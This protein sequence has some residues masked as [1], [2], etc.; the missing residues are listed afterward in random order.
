M[1]GAQATI[2]TAAKRARLP[3]RKNPYWHGVSGGRGGVSL[4]YRKSAKGRPGGWIG[5]I[6]VEG[7]RIEERVGV[8]D[9]PGAGPGALPYPKAVTAALDWAHQR[10]AAIEARRAGGAEDARPTVHTAVTAYIAERRGRSLHGR[11]AHSRLTKHVLADDAFAATPLGKLTADLIGAWRD[12]L[13]QELSASTVN[14]LLNDLRAALNAAAVK[15]RRQLPAH[16]AAE[17]RAGTKAAPEAGEARRQILSDGDV[18]RIVDEAFAIEPEGDFGRLVLLA[19]ATGARFS[20]LAA[21]AVADVQAE[22]LRIMVPAS[23]KGRSAKAPGRIAVPIG[24]DVLE[25]LQPALV[26]RGGHEP[27]LMHWIKRQTGPWVWE[28]SGRSAWKS[29]SEADRLWSRTVAAAR[30]PPETVMYALRHSS[31][32]RGLRAGLPVRLVAALHDTSTAMVEKHYAA[33]I[34][35]A[36]EELARRAVMLLASLAPGTHGPEANEL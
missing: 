20:Q 22:R 9:D 36:T 30:L 32:V 2:D 33:F 25:R 10:Y 12:R 35:D 3:A 24:P 34:V 11:D 29:A 16:L 6:V 17:I 5:K 14:R 1:A 13:S 15:H 18:R 23:K 4:G 26:G 21:L 31:I 19:A 8:A 28:R 7:A 27:L